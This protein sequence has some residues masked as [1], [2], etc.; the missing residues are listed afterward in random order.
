MRIE[1]EIKLPQAISKRKKRI[2]KLRQV[3]S[4]LLLTKGK[5][6]DVEGDDVEDE[7]E[8]TKSKEE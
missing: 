8:E 2:E 5:G 3:S 6:D 1:L 4:T 7:E